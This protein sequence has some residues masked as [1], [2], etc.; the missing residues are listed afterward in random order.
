MKYKISQLK[1]LYKSLRNWKKQTSDGQ[2]KITNLTNENE[3]L[4]G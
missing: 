3:A 2:N 1:N 4:T